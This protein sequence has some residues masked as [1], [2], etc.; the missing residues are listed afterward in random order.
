MKTLDYHEIIK[1]DTT[2]FVTLHDNVASRVYYGKLQPT[3]LQDLGIFTRSIL[4]GIARI[5]HA[6]IKS[7]A[8]NKKRSKLKL[9]ELPY[10][11][12][13]TIGSA[14]YASEENEIVTTCKLKGYDVLSVYPS[15]GIKG[16]SSPHILPYRSF[17]KAR[18]YLHVM[19]QW[20]WHVILGLKNLITMDSKQRSLYV[21]SITSIQKFFIDLAAIKQIISIQG[22]P[23][24]SLSLCPTASTSIIFN[25][26][27]RRQGIVTGGLRTQTTSEELEH[28]AINADIMYCKS[29]HELGIFNNIFG[30]DGPD[31]RKGCILSLPKVYPLEPLHLPDEYILLLGTAPGAEQSAGSYAQYNT[32]IFSIGANSG[33][34]IVFKGHNLAR[35]YD[36]QW[37]SQHTDII[38]PC[39]RISD[40][41]RNRELVERATVIV[42]AASTLLY[43]AILCEKPIIIIDTYLKLFNSSEFSASPIFFVH[44]NDLIENLHIDWKGI[45]GSSRQA[46]QWFR[47]NYFL[48][49]GAHH[50]IKD[51]LSSYSADKLHCKSSK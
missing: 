41:C 12:L 14:K 17:L 34:P 22:K 45:V 25:D 18:D 40:I 24:A 38:N 13:I 20:G 11:L 51:L 43:Y 9:V 31:L 29:L 28:Q 16:S 36:N 50:V 33:L 47:E 10:L 4:A 35:D 15:H 32:R 23:V 37:F 26:H 6:I 42:S 2:N 46:N 7:I 3:M 5:G 48:D 27:L 49:H 30:S 21:L 8:G 44:W 1:W 39:I 19:I